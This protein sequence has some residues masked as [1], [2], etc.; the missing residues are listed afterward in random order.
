MYLKQFNWTILSVMIILGFSPRPQ[1]IL[2][3]NH[4]S[5]M[6]NPSKQEFHGV[7]FHGFSFIL[8]IRRVSFQS[9]FKTFL[10]A[11]SYRM[12]IKKYDKS[13]KANRS[14]RADQ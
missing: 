6:N 14:I 12:N 10:K 11:V 2:E 5:E 7:S 3:T 8:T 1:L 4:L 13:E 9:S